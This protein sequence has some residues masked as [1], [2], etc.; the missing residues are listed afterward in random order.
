MNYISSYNSPI[1][2]ISL[3]SDGTNLTSLFFKDDLSA[4]LKYKEGLKKDDLDVFIKTRK[5]LDIYFSGKNPEFT[6]PLLLEGTKFQK[7]VWEIIYKIPY[8]KSS[9]YGKIAE[10]L[11]NKYHIK[12]MSAQ[13]VGGAGKRNPISIIIPCHRVLSSTKKL[14]GYR[15]GLDRKVYLLKLE[16]IN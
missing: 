3:S 8:G 5:W 2:E 1:G 11:A 6:I 13:A 15:G 10:E 16:K 7:D 4:P 12:K 14:T 9:T